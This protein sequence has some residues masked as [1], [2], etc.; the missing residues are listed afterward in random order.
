MPGHNVVSRTATVV[1]FVQSGNLDRAMA[2]F[3][4]MSERNLV[5]WTTLIV[6]NANGGNG[7]RALELFWAMVLDGIHPDEI[8][9]TGALIACDHID[10]GWS[11]F[12]SMGYNF[13][14]RPRK[15]QF[16]CVL[17]LLGRMGH[18][19][20][21]EDLIHSMPFEP[22]LMAWGALMGACRIHRDLDRG[23]RV[24]KE[25]L[26]LDPG[27]AHVLLAQIYATKPKNSKNPRCPK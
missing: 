16:C 15:E 12:V 18:L 8:A 7:G 6:A 25:L 4:A 22:D 26:D 11:Y 24:A 20:Q 10:L 2:L 17:D 27:T 23:E 14:L 13:G 5:T 19:D 1:A 9:F 3:D 21:A